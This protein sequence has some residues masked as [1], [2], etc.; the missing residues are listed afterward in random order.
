MHTRQYSEV[1]GAS[2]VQDGT[3]CV[4]RGKMAASSKT[5]TRNDLC[6]LGIDGGDTADGK[7]ATRN[8]LCALR[9][10]SNETANIL[11]L[12]TY[13]KLI[14]IVYFLWCEF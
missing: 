8:D 1:R 12:N 13:L 5:A 10:D 7:T 11:N 9:L 4:C 2:Y 3:T 6:T 14:Y